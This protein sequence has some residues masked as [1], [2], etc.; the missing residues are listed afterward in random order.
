MCSLA[1]VLAIVLSTFGVFKPDDAGAAL[2]GF[3]PSVA[4]GEAKFGYKRI[5][6]DG[7]VSIAVGIAIINPN[8]QDDYILARFDT[9][10]LIGSHC[11]RIYCGMITEAGAA[12]NI[13]GGKYSRILAIYLTGINSVAGQFICL[14]DSK[15]KIGRTFCGGTPADIVHIYIDFIVGRGGRLNVTRHRYS[16]PRPIGGKACPRSN[17]IGGFGSL[18]GL[19]DST[20]L[21]LSSGRKPIGSFAG[22]NCGL[23]LPTNGPGLDLRSVSLGLDGP[24]LPRCIRRENGSVFGL[25]TAGS[26]QKLGGSSLRFPRAL[27]FIHCNGLSAGGGGEALGISGKVVSINTPAVHLIKLKSEDYH[28]KNGANGEN[29]CEYAK[30]TSPCCHN[31]FVFRMLILFVSP[32]SMPEVLKGVEHADGDRSP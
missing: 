12:K 20:G 6:S 10:H 1:M 32:P 3:V 26:S 14:I 17:L 5:T 30:L 29:Y 8:S 2:I 28:V 9:L 4:V 13:R 22:K 16:N 25:G 21:G 18:Q 27:K 11:S 19:Q 15:R 7:F 23:S 24:Q 31:S